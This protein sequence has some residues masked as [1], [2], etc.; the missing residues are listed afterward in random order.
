MKRE[1]QELRIKL[2]KQGNLLQSTIECLKTTKQ[3]KENMELFITSHCRC[4]RAR[5]C[6]GER[7]GVFWTSQ[8]VA[9]EA[10]TGRLGVLPWRDSY[11]IIQS[12]VSWVIVDAEGG[13]DGR[14]H[15]TSGG[16]ARNK[17]VRKYMPRQYGLTG[18][19]YFFGLFSHFSDQDMCPFTKGKDW[20]GGKETATPVRATESPQTPS[21]CLSLH[22][23][24][25][26]FDLPE[27]LWL[28]SR[29]TGPL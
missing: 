1:L 28:T 9:N 12:P 16:V 14:H 18:H 3:Q 5:E 13:K 4:P 17:W 26:C 24:G 22:Y 29:V 27:D 6:T 19:F 11:Y 21:L 10:W 8:S 2:S 7:E 20:L 23:P 15:E 25:V